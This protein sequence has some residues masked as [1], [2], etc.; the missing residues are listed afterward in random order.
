M[1]VLSRKV[2][3]KIVITVVDDKGNELESCEIT[4]TK[5]IGNRVWLGFKAGSNVKIDRKEIYNAKHD[6]KLEDMP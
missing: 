1:L 5:N 6:I 4:V 3:E 2:D